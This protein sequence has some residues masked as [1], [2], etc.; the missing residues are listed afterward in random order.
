MNADKTNT[1]P[2]KRG[3]SRSTNTVCPFMFDA[4]PFP[5]LMML[6]G[7]LSGVSAFIGG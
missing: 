1:E 5:G 4:V 6:F 3:E 2:Q 7:L